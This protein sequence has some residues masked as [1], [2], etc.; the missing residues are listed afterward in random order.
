MP[1]T[2]LNA[3]TH[4]NS[5]RVGPIIGLIGGVASGKSR[6]AQLLTRHGGQHVE[7]DRLGHRCLEQPD[8]RKQLIAK[9]TADILDAQGRIDR[10][11]LAARVFGDEPTSRGRREALEAIVHPCISELARAAIEQHRQS[12]ESG[13]LVLDAPLLLEVGWDRLCDWVLLV[14]TPAQRRL[15]WAT[16]RGWSEA[17]W[18][19]REASQWSLDRKRAA[20]THCI[21]ND[22]SVETLADQVDA[23]L[24]SWPN[25]RSST[26]Q[27]SPPA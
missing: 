16:Q 24:A 22:G 6:V 8:I 9:F 20:A 27:T 7:A 13:P 14:D 1:P 4:P 15:Q 5:P 23:L 25:W 3:S 19:R 2:V 12:G 10:Q 18:K 26:P 21:R 11:R 17:E